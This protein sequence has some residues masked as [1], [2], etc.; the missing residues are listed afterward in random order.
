[1]MLRG[2]EVIPRPLIEIDSCGVIRSVEQYED[3]DRL[4]GT[5]FYAGVM[6]AGFVNSHSHL[7]LSYLKG[8]IT[9]HKGFAAFARQIG[10]VRGEASMEERLRSISRAELELRREGVVA[11]GDILNGNTSMECKQHSP[12]KFRNFG[13]VFGLS[14]TSTEQMSWILSHPNSSITP[15]STYSL[16]DKLFREIASLDSSAPLSIHFKESPS[17]EELYHEQGSLWEWY[18]RVGFECDF[19]HYGSAAQR[20]VESTPPHRSVIL[21][22][23]CCVTQRDIDTIMEHF[24]APVYWALCPCSNDYISQ[25]APPVELLRQNGLNICIGTDSLASNTSLSMLDEMR[26]LQSAAPLHEILDWATRQGASALCFDELG[27][28]QEGKSPGINIISAIDYRTMTL[29]AESRVSV[30]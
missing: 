3:V 16:N 6:T 24:T 23:N 4:S 2:G 11:V 26:A 30:I 14:T 1:M 29:T 28:I 22:H 9:P 17:E 21:V 25:I 18:S 12:I 13:E 19:M 5:E 7:E 15:H 8:R 20:I 10:E 27:D